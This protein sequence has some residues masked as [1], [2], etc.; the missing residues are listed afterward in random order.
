MILVIVLTS[1]RVYSTT[2]RS[3]FV[4]RHKG[5]ATRREKKKR[6]NFLLVPL[7]TMEKFMWREIREESVGELERGERRRRG[8]EEKKERE[9]ERR[10]EREEEG[11]RERDHKTEKEE[12]SVA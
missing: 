10:H 6:M 4:K 1:D 8:G 3:Q 11:E 2:S 5:G 7:L 9:R 12:R